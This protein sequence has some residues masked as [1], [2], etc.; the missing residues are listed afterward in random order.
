MRY[1]TGSKKKLPLGAGAM[2]ATD[3]DVLAKKVLI[4]WDVD[5]K[6]NHKH[7]I[8]CHPNY[9]FPEVIILYTSSTLDFFDV[10]QMQL[11]LRC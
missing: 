9:N 8:H 11:F 6:V 2:R 3:G 5:I 1:K 10:F 7:Y 4:V